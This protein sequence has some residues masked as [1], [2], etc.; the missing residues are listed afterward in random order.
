MKK[1]NPKIALI[2][3]ICLGVV[4]LVAGGVFLGVWLVGGESEPEGPIVRERTHVGARGTVVTEENVEELL[5]QMNEPSIFDHYRVRMNNNW[6]FNTATSPS[7]NMFVENHESNPGT[8]FF[9]VVLSDTD[10][11]VFSSPYIPLGGSLRNIT[12]D[13]A[14][15]PG[16][17]EAIVIYHLVDEYYE[18]QTT[19]SVGVTLSIQ[20]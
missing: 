13:T 20:G 2:A 11:L 8:V 6:V 15:P 3:A 12:L 1:T 16:E 14:L 10:E 17:Y 5:A 19:V 18:V 7:T 9:D 4:A